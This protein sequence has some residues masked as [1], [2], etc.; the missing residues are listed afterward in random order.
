[1]SGQSLDEVTRL[2]DEAQS[3]L[4]RAKLDGAAGVPD[5]AAGYD[6]ALEAVDQATRS[7]PADGSLGKAEFDDLLQELVR[8]RGRIIDGVAAAGAAPG[9]SAAPAPRQLPEP[10]SDLAGYAR[11]LRWWTC[12]V[13]LI[14]ALACGTVLGAVLVTSEAPPGERWAVTGAFAAILGA[15]AGILFIALALWRRAA[16]GTVPDPAREPAYGGA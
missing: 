11:R 9:G 3:F 15:L 12:A 1:M 13:L 2:R 14:Y 10:H 7:L 8:L 5:A 6:A 4:R 16:R